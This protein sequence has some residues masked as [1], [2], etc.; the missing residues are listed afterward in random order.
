MFCNNNRFNISTFIL[1]IFLN[2]SSI[3]WP[4]GIAHSIKPHKWHERVWYD[5]KLYPPLNAF[6][7][8]TS[9]TVLSS[10]QFSDRTHRYAYTVKESPY[11]Y[12][13][14]RATNIAPEQDLVC[15]LSK[16]WRFSQMR[17]L[18]HLTAATAASEKE[19]THVELCS[20]TIFVP[21]RY[22]EAVFGWF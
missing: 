2:L 3:G 22:M 4:S 10:K 7:S 15:I 19:E 17:V 11:P 6:A 14:S 1:T 5:Q 16:I 18:E 12:Q 20:G 8:K 13:M 9:K 21:W